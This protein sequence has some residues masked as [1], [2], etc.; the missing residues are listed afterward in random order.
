MTVLDPVVIAQLG[1][2]HLRPRRILDGFY[3]GRHQNR[4]RGTSKDFSEHRAYLPGDDP[5]TLDWK[6]LA[7]TDRLVVKQYDEETSLT[8]VLLIDDSASMSFSSGTHPTK[9]D[10]AKQQAAALGYL[11]ISQGD[12]ASLVASEVAVPPVSKRDLF[13]RILTSL[14]AIHPRGMWNPAAS[15][16]RMR[17]V[18]KRR[19]LVAVFSDLMGDFDTLI[20]PL[21]NLT[22]QGYDGLVIQILDPAEKDLP[23][24][25]PIEFTDAETGEKLRTN[26]D[27]IRQDYRDFVQQQIARTAQALQSADL[28]FISLST[29]TPFEKGLG[30]YL[31]WRESHL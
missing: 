5:K 29:D 3:A 26:A 22:H 20:A 10:Y 11:L 16:E 9:L 24:E 25:G 30:H 17:T 4:A 15:L 1:K 31:S 6:V 28:D 21:R 8:G 27:A 23:Y 2:L 12:A 19:G 7:K 18:L 14:E 13:D